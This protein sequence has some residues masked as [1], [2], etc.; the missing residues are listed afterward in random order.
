MDPAK[1][2]ESVL[3]IPEARFNQL[4]LRHGLS[5]ARPEVT[6]VLL[7]PAGFT[8]RPRGEVESDPGYKQLIPYVVLR[9]HDQ[10]YRYTRGDAGSETRLHALASIGLGGHIVAEDATDL[11]DAYRQGLLRELR[12]EVEINSTVREHLLGYIYDAA[13]EVG[14]VH[15]GIV[16]LW[17]LEEPLVIALETAVEHAEFVSLRELQREQ[18]R[19]ETWSQWVLEVLLNEAQS[20]LR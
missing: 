13:T 10:V 14:R 2:Q 8:F 4:G 5:L 15:V 7:D 20:E 3:V 1:A 9:W 17:T 11:A 16:H 6:A 19:L 12:E 18:D